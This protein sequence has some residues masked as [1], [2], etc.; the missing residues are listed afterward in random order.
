LGY[1]GFES[2]RSTP[3]NDYAS[4]FSDLPEVDMVAQQTASELEA[5]TSQA[6][7]DALET[8]RLRILQW[9]QIEDERALLDER[10]SRL[11][12]GRGSLR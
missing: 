12:I 4:A 9:Q 8:Q 5:P 2:A 6:R 10:I 11:K 7:K 1:N 3:T